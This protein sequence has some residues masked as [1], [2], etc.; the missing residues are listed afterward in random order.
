MYCVSFVRGTI[1]MTCSRWARGYW[2]LYKTSHGNIGL[3]RSSLYCN[4]L[5]EGV[6]DLF[7]NY[8][9]NH[10]HFNKRWYFNIKQNETLCNIRSKEYTICTDKKL[11]LLNICYC[12]STIS[13]KFVV[14]PTL[15]HVLLSESAVTLPTHV[16]VFGTYTTYA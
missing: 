11:T 2:L 6:Y 9:T 7:I 14:F 4:H 10:L 15:T 12:S 8:F 5:K 13:A 3:K 16:I 1:V